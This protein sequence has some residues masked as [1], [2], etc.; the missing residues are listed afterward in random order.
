MSAFNYKVRYFGNLSD[1]LHL[2]QLAY[3]LLGKIEDDELE[4]YNNHG[5]KMVG[6]LP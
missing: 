4:H 1:L 5:D 3:G 6:I 2:I